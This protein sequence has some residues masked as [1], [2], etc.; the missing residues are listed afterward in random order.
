MSDL[1]KARET[2]H[3]LVDTSTQEEF[4]TFRVENQLFGIPILQVQDILS[5][6]QIDPIP[7]APKKIAGSINLRGRI[8]TVLDIR[9][10]LN[11]TQVKKNPEEVVP[12]SKPMGVT[13]D[14]EDDQYTLLVDEIGEVLKIDSSKIDKS[15]NTI[16]PEWRDNADGI[17]RLNNELM[18]IL[19][20]SKVI[21]L[22]AETSL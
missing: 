18:V 20:I 21:G 13:V 4:V 6:E 9:T 15:T 16:S 8:V 22:P 7:L 5:P 19:A 12:V 3:S 11:L 2:E 17:Y 14:F 1:I 10:V